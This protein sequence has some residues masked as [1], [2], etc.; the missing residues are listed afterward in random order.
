MVVDVALVGGGL[1]NALIA[2]RLLERRPELRL[3]IIERGDALG[4][5]HT[6]SFHGSDLDP[7]TLA[8]IR[9]LASATWRGYAVAFPGLRRV[10]AGD[11]HSIR[12]TD[13]ARRLSARLGEAVRLKRT[14]TRVTDAT[15]VLDGGEVIE[16]ATVI[17]GR[18]FRPSA[19]TRYGYQ[20]FL[21]LD[22]ELVEPHGLER[23]IIMDAT[24]PQDDGY[25]FFYLLPWSATE[26]LI[27]D[28]VYGEGPDHDADKSRLAIEGYV[29]DRGWK[30][31]AIH[32]EERG[33]LPI[34]LGRA[35]LP[36]D[37]P[38]LPALVGAGA[39][40]FHP[41][42]GYSL[43]YA[44]HAADLV[45]GLRPLG[46]AAVRRT[47]GAF[48]RAAARRHR[49]FHFLNRLLFL[50]ARPAERCRVMERFHRLPEATIAR[51]YADRLTPLDRVRLLV[52]KPPIPIRRA[53]AHLREAS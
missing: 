13:L 34:P 12:S 21:G 6:W 15:V 42:T 48:G 10:L 3:T 49:L 30:I 24:V 20:R 36:L 50:A 53:L 5:N 32:R 22:L 2:W 4:G 29:R 9:P 39:G 19:G 45:A 38:G 1:A 26:V 23:P 8:W 40:L 7:E 16:A 11:Y 31:L 51:F 25:R 35:D 52:G 27:E 44:A 28:T 33:S 18:G 37:G 17:D 14:A 41:T 47:I 46:T 43:P